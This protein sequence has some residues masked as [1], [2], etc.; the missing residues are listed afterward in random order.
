MRKAS[1]R[2]PILT[3]EIRQLTSIGHTARA[4]GSVV[5]TAQ[6]NGLGF[7]DELR[8]LGPTGRP[9]AETLFRFPRPFT[10]KVDM[11]RTVGPLG[12]KGGI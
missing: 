1:V 7:A 8:I 11:K 9:F 12:R 6:A 10:G 4:E 3:L 2:T 5:P